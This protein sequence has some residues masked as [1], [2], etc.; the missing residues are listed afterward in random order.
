MSNG[1]I[2][3]NDGEETMHWRL[4]RLVAQLRVRPPETGGGGIL[5]D[6]DNAAANRAGAGEMLEQRLAVAAADGPGE[7]GEVLVE[8]AEHFQHRVLVG[9]EHVAPHD[10]IGGRDAGE[11]A[12]TAGGKLQHLGFRDPFKLIRCAY[13]GISD[14]MRQMA[15]D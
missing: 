13:D 7:L 14:Q 4:L 1:E 10:R 5:A 15:G 2:A 8:G 12:K 11:I 9:E 6:L 3:R